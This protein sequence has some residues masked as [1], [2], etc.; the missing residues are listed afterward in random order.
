[1]HM[2]FWMLQHANKQEIQTNIIPFADVEGRDDSDNY[3]ICK[4]CH[5]GYVFFMLNQGNVPNR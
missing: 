5:V 1:M 3:V 2:K 4:V